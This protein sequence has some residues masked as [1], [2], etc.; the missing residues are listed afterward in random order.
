[1]AYAG[2]HRSRFFVPL[3]PAI[4]YDADKNLHNATK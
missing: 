4:H 2:V 1:M 3:Q